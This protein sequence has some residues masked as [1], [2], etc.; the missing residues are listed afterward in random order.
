[1]LKSQ[2]NYLYTALCLKGYF[3]LRLVVKITEFSRFSILVISPYLSQNCTGS[4]CLFVGA[5]I[6]LRGGEALIFL[7][8]VLNFHCHKNR[9]PGPSYRL[10][11]IEERRIIIILVQA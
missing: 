5:R 4:S 10:R 3:I 8:I 1:M 7:F 2:I 11:G 9:Q 6:Y